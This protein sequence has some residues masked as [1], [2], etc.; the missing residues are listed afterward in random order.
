MSLGRPVVVAPCGAL[1]EVCG[2]AA[3]Y[4]D[5]KD[6]AAWATAIRHLL[7]DDEAHVSWSARALARAGMF[8]WAKSARELLSL[9]DEVAAGGSYL[10]GPGQEGR[11]PVRP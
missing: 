2:D 1:P 9:I 3:L 5:S 7:D 8:P 6:P 10:N 4:A 11:E